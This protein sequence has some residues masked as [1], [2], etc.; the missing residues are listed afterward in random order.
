MQVVT[1]P[2]EKSKSLMLP[3][4]NSEVEINIEKNASLE[5]G[6]LCLEPSVIELNINL[7]GE[8]AA[9]KVGAAFL[10]DKEE[11]VSIN[12]V[13]NHS[14]PATTSDVKIYGCLAGK[15]RAK[16]TGNIKIEKTGQKTNAFF[17]SHALLLDKNCRA[18]SI[19]ALEIEANDVKAG[20][21]A[22]TTKISEE[23]LFYCRSRG[24][25]EK[26]AEKIIVL[27]FLQRAFT[28]LPFNVTAK[29]EE[30][31]QKM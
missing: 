10:G 11:S 4:G 25:Q 20:H 1:I 5:L 7:V 31:W 24:L 17:A 26:N 21:S 27:G 28:Q 6:L 18:E 22:S 13:V 12:T 30:K 3:P 23:Q 16:S 19:P 15:S 8:G 2:Q 9:A 29:V 14:A